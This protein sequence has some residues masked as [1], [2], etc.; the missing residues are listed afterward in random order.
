MP[1]IDIG[2]FLAFQIDLKNPIFIA[3][4]NEINKFVN[5]AFE[6]EPNSILESFKQYQFLMERNV[7]Q[8][9]KHLFGDAKDLVQLDKKEINQKLQ[10]YTKAKDSLQK[11]I[12]D[13][14]NCRFF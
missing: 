13:N 11:L 4:S 10:E 8:I 7:N 3:S 14:K 12:G 2:K 1:L 5:W 6:E 9:V